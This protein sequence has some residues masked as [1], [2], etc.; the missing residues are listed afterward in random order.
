MTEATINVPGDRH[1]L[2]QEEIVRITHLLAYRKAYT[3]SQK[4]TVARK[5]RQE[6]MKRAVEYVRLQPELM[7]KVR[8]EV[9]KRMEGG[10]R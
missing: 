9:Q 5:R 7:E 2:T 10:T 4:A 3:K 6:R 8:E 1:P